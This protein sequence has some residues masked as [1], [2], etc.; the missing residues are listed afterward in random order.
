MTK[1]LVPSRFDTQLSWDYRASSDVLAN[2]YER[3]KTAQWNAATDI[4][5]SVKVPYG[6]PLSEDSPLRVASYENSP[7]AARGR[8]AW[9]MFRWEFQNWMVSQFLHGEQ[10]AMIASARLVES[11]P[12]LES[13]LYAASQGADEARHVEAFSRYIKTGIPH[14]YSVSAPL[15][16]LMQDLLTDSRWDITALGMQVLIEALAMAAFRTVDSIFNDALVKQI[17]RLV[18]RDEARHLTFGITS[19]RG[20]YSELTTAELSE[21]ESFVLEAAHLMRRRFLLEDIWERLE[22]PRVRG[23][24]YAATDPVMTAYRHTIFA[25]I[26]SA[27]SHIGLMTGRVRDGLVS[28]E[29]LDPGCERPNPTP[30]RHH[31]HG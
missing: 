10:A 29:L 17:A 14:P 19:L 31:D 18:A 13:K 30:A 11:M 23:V 1:K 5:W 12:D 24:E 22:V 4:D 16:A 26:V 28:L 2:L 25:K 9:D 20:I 8:A 6:E 7:F 3:S 21:R 15:E 27:L